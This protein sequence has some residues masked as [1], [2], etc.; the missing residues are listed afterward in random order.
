MVKLGEVDNHH[1]SI[2]TLLGKQALVKR[3][4]FMVKLMATLA[5]KLTATS[6][7]TIL[8]GPDRCFVLTITRLCSTNV[9]L[10]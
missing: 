9:R 3:L 7:P 2:I 6:V 4:C 1:R 5:A 10:Y 8:A